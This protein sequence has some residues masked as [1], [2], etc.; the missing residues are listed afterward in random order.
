V[1]GSSGHLNSD[2]TPGELSRYS[3]GLLIGRPEFDSQQ[4]REFSF[5][6]NVQND[7]GFYPHFY[8]MR[9]GASSPR[10]KRLGRETNCSPPSNAEVN[11]GLH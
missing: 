1:E 11:N 3:E 10:I 2:T 6:H 5:L 7:S 9:S 8:P 4:R